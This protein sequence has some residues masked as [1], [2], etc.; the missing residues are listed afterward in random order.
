MKDFAESFYKSKAWRK[1]RDYIYYDRD[2]RICVRCGESGKIVHH[3]IWLTAENINDPLISLNE[4][5]LETLC[6]T[7]H[8]IEHNGQK[9]LDGELMFDED[10]D[11]T[12]NDA[13]VY[14]APQSEPIP[15]SLTDSGLVFDEDGNLV[16]RSDHS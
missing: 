16:E 8:S 14:S 3:K 10:G 13:K 9:P 6:E 12:P 2:H 11:I 5:N 1:L 7:C 4:E 15:E